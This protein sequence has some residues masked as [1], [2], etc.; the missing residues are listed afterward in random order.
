MILSITS[1]ER[2]ECPLFAYAPRILFILFYQ[3][4]A[5]V[6]KREFT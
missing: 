1:I 3:A 4:I 5:E 2:G 6:E